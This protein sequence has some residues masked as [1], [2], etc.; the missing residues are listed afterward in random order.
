M[1]SLEVLLR[2]SLA[3]AALVQLARVVDPDTAM[4]LVYAANIG[5]VKG[6]APIGHADASSGPHDG[7]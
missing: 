5:L 3:R 1:T 7:E 6:G 2:I 4:V